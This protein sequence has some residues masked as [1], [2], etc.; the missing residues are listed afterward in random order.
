MYQKPYSNAS[1]LNKKFR[2]KVNHHRRCSVLQM[3]DVV[4]SGKRNI[5]IVEARHVS[6]EYE[7]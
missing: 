2:S 6:N 7:C 3:A 1:I 4:T 5:E